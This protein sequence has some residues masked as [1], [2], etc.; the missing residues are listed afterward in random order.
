[1]PILHTGQKYVRRKS[2][3]RKNVGAP[4]ELLKKLAH[5]IRNC[6]VTNTIMQ[7][8]HIV[9]PDNLNF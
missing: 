4:N 6:K 7:V 1:M 8:P 9:L 5:Y 3:R 2:V